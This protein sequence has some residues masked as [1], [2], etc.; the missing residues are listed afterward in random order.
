[1]ALAAPPLPPSSAGPR[2]TA[3]IDE[4]LM[5][6]REVDER[7]LRQPSIVIGPAEA[8]RPRAG[9]P[10]SQRELE[11]LLERSFGVRHT[12][13]MAVSTVAG[14]FAEHHTLT[15]TESSDR[16]AEDVGIAIWML[17]IGIRMQ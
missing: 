1:L 15:H 4:R 13:R 14:K 2:D 9:I 10:G 3:L 16:L 8:P 17:Q 7:R 11:I 6:P 5:A 12:C